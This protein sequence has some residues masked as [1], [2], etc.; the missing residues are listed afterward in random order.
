MTPPQESSQNCSVY[1]AEAATE[2][3]SLY[4]LDSLLPEEKNGFET[5][6]ASCASCRAEVHELLEVVGA[7]GWVTGDEANARPSEKVRD[8]LLF[9]IGNEPSPTGA[10]PGSE[11]TPRGHAPDVQV[12]KDWQSAGGG[13]SAEGLTVVRDGQGDWQ[14]TGVDGITAKRLSV[15]T[16]TGFVT[17]I[18]RM[19][20]GTSYPSHRH[21]GAEE[22]FVLEGD[23]QVAGSTLRAGDYQK[24]DSSS[25]HGVQST[26]S[27]CTLLLRSSQHDELL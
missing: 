24:A 26:V 8:D 1:S 7:V 16:D 13:E 22:C 2:L 18:V 20:P 25:I 19:E 10:P 14:P 6:L 27:G 15:D 12:W 11:G 9:R 21:A 23:L 17:M 5:H 4:V 3:A